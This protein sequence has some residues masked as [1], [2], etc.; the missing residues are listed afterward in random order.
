MIAA[1][2]MRKSTAVAVKPG[3]RLPLPQCV[4]RLDR[5]GIRR[6]PNAWSDPGEGQ[7]S[8]PP[9]AQNPRIAAPHPDPLPAEVRQG[10]CFAWGRGRAGALPCD[11]ASAGIPNH[12]LR[13]ASLTSAPMPGECLRPRTVTR[14]T[15]QQCR[16]A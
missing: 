9:H 7:G 16:R 3:A 14:L 8:E 10:N 5:L 15:R 2:V 11:A 12:C 13:N 6:K 1:M 4:E